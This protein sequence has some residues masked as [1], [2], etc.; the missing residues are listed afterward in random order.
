MKHFMKDQVGS[1][2]LAYDIFR[3]IMLVGSLPLFVGLIMIL[4]YKFKRKKEKMKR[5]MYF[6]MGWT[7]LLIIISVVVVLL[8]D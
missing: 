3:I 5:F 7:L 6:V 1:S 4:Y 2:S 8:V